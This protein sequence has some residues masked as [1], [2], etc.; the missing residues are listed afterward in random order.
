EPLR[1]EVKSKWAA[2]I[3]M[4]IWPIPYGKS[5]LVLM[6]RFRIS[7]KF[8]L[9]LPVCGETGLICRLMSIWESV[10]NVNGQKLVVRT[11][12]QAIL[13]PDTC[14]LFFFGRIY[15]IR[16]PYS[17]LRRGQFSRNRKSDGKRGFPL[18]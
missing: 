15:Q 7:S 2:M 18:T 3:F 10:M 1:T 8:T 4:K 6:P 16:L 14:P 17:F 13:F 9:L 11:E 12:L 5:A